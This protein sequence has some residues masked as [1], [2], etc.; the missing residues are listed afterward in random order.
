M[1][2]SLKKRTKRF[3]RLMRGMRR[4]ESGLTPLDAAFGIPTSISLLL[5]G[6]G[7]DNFSDKTRARR[8]AEGK[9]RRA[10]RRAGR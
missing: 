5:F 6:V 1:T 7:I 8:R 9:R 2:A 4:P 3:D 10:A